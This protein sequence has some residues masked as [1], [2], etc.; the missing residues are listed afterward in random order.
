MNKYNYIYE[1]FDVDILDIYIDVE[2]FEWR[3]VC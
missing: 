1:I 3:E 2:D